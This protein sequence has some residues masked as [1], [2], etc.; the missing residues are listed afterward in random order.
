[1][2]DEEHFQQIKEKEITRLTTPIDYPKFKGITFNVAPKDCEGN[3]VPI[4]RGLRNRY[5]LEPKPGILS[6]D[7]ILMYAPESK[8]ASRIRL[9]RGIGTQSDKSTINDNFVISYF[10]IILFFV[11]LS[12][13]VFILGNS[14]VKAI[15]LLIAI[16]VIGIHV[17][18]MYIKDYSDPNYKP[19]QLRCE[20]EKLFECDDLFLLFESKE[21]IAREMIEKKFPAPQ[22]TNSKFNA[23]LDNCRSVVESQIE[24]INALIP[25]Q[26]TKVEIDS[27][28][29]LIKQLISKVDDLNNELLLSEEND[30]EDVID[31][32]D[33]LISS[34]KDYK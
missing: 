27:R 9:K 29:K 31:D 32:V 17:Y 21:K 2:N 28:K 33:E 7:E 19:A 18:I 20:D 4:I 13:P 1:M 23:V 25:T 26:K 30:I 3:P 16:I 24:I 15:I 5:A 22:L 10:I 6:D 34:V 11:I 12:P 14:I 8:E